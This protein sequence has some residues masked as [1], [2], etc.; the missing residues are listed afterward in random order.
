MRKFI[1]EL[2]HGKRSIQEVEIE[3]IT[4]VEDPSVTWL[5]KGEFRARVVKPRTFKEKDGTPAVWCSFVFCEDLESAKAKCEQMVRESFDFELRKYETA[6]T[7]EQVQQALS[8][9]EVV[10]L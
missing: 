10:M 9:V 4:A 6:F 8:E 3:V 7:E 2:A 5:P 1:I